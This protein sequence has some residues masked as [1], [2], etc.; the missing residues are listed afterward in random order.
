MIWKKTKSIFIHIPKTGGTSIE[1]YFQD[2]LKEQFKKDEKHITAIEAIDLYHSQWHRYFTFSFV[3]NPWDRIYSYWYNYYNW[4]GSEERTPKT[5]LNFLYQLSGRH[6]WR[7]SLIMQ[8]HLIP[9]VDWL[10]NEKGNI[11]VNYIGRFES[12]RQHFNIIRDKL[13]IDKTYALGN[14]LWLKDKPHYS[15]FYQKQHIQIVEEI[16]EKDIEKFN[17]RYDDHCLN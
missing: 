9:Q 5:F 12:I 4:F 7:G 17:Y 2:Y 15:T 13:N 11:I 8:K 14:I 3:R 1:I 10:S 6:K 16:Y